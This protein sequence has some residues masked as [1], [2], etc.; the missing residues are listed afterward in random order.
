MVVYDP[1]IALEPHSHSS[2]NFHLP[3]IAYHTITLLLSF[4][5]QG[6]EMYQTIF[7][8]LKKIKFLGVCIAN[9]IQYL[10]LK[11]FHPRAS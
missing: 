6:P 10:I 4:F 9:Q 3:V 1:L 7:V 8:C 5:H 11:Y 2:S